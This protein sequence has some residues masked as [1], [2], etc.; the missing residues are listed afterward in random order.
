[1]ASRIPSL[2]RQTVSAS[3]FFGVVVRVLIRR[4]SFD[5]WSRRIYGRGLFQARV[6]SVSRVRSSIISN[7]KV[8]TN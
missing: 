5:V 8:D 2:L 4:G 1:M 3:S 7:M 6:E